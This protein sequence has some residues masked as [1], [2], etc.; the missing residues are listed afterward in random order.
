[1][2][3]WTWQKPGFPLCS[4]R[5]DHERSEY[6]QTVPGVREAYQRLSNHLGTDQFVWCYTKP[7]Q[8]IVLPVHTEVEWILEIPSDNIL[9]FIDDIV[10]NRILGIECGLPRYLEL[11][12]KRASMECF[13]DDSEAR[14]KYVKSQRKQFWGQTPPLGDW[15]TELFVKEQSCEFVSAIVPHPV[16]EAWVVQSPR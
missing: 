1:M 9:A 8:R 2:R 12:W 6:V 5:V 10:W 7:D 11:Q 4:G 13:P 15:L 16:R 14:T 3:L